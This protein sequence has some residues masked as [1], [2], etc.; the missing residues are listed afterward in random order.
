MFF[1]RVDKIWFNRD[2]QAC[3]IFRVFVAL[4]AERVS[5]AVAYIGSIDLNVTDVS[6]SFTY[7]SEL[8]YQTPAI[9]KT[10]TEDPDAVRTL[11]SQ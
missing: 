2:E 5:R 10:C 3:Q 1:V 4:V 9:V 11:R 6:R 7:R 8:D